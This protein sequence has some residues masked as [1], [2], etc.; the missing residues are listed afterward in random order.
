MNVY[1]FFL[2]YSFLFCFF[3]NLQRHNCES[4]ACEHDRVQRVSEPRRVVV[5]TARR[6]RPGVA[7]DFIGDG[8]S[9]RVKD[10]KGGGTDGGGITTHHLIHCGGRH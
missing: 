9:D 4:D 3:L 5:V 1:V 6:A 8:E 10:H 7:G 2:L